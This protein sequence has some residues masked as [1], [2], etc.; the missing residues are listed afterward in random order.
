MG[1]LELDDRF[2]S[3]VD[4]SGDC[5]VWTA[6]VMPSGYGR[7]W[8]EGALEYAHV[9]SC[10]AVGEWFPTMQVDHRCRNKACVNPAHLEAVT[11]RENI[12]RSGAISN[13]NRIRTHCPQGHE[14]TPENTL[15]YRG[16]RY[17]RRC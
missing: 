11:Q 13:L 16:R 12:L 17:C 6:Y 4:A 9:L 14:Y 2:W 1:V 3:K 8:F 5:W 7:F 15:V 10:R